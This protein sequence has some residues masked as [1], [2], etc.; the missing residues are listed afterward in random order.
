MILC[1]GCKLKNIANNC[2]CNL[3]KSKYFKDIINECPCQTCLI[4]GMC[5][6]FCPL[7][8]N[9]LLKGLNKIE[10][11]DKSYLKCKVDYVKIQI[12][13]RLYLLLSFEYDIILNYRLSLTCDLGINRYGSYQPAD[14]GT[15]NKLAF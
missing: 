4:K 9:Y 15:K 11:I 1:K 7:F 2:H 5:S 8:L 3:D 14:E 13:S 6:Q 12:V 10:K